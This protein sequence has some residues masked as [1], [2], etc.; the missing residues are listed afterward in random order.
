MAQAPY[1][2]EKCGGEIA[3]LA[4][5][6]PTVRPPTLEARQ[7]IADA[8]EIVGPYFNSFAV[9]LLGDNARINQPILEG[10]MLLA[11]PRFPTRFFSSVQAAAEWLCEADARRLHGATLLPPSSSPP[12]KAC[13]GS[14]PIAAT[15]AATPE[16][17]PPSA[18]DHG[19]TAPASAV[20][21]GVHCS[22]TQALH[23]RRRPLRRTRWRTW[24]RPRLARQRAARRRLAR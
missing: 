15:S 18:P 21:A 13:G 3:Y 19:Q 20:M 14:R 5:I 12:P 7:K 16:R 2:L 22:P 6:E 10:L 4:L 17:S 1:T 9:V 11:R 23:D 24:P 8:L